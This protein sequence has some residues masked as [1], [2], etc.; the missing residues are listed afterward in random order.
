VG[1]GALVLV[2]LAVGVG[3]SRRTIRRVVVPLTRVR[4]VLAALAAE[5]HDARVEPR[6]P[7]EIAAIADGVNRLADSTDRLRAVEEAE[8]RL[9][10]RLVRLS[11]TVR[12]TQDDQ[13]IMQRGLAELGTALGLERAYLRILTN[14]SAGRIEAEWHDPELEPLPREVHHHTPG[15]SDELDELV[16]NG[17]ARVT[18]DVTDDPA[19]TSDQGRAWVRLVGAG[20]TMAVPVVAGS[21]PIAVLSVIDPAPRAWTPA[22]IHFA[23]SVAAD[24]GRALADARLYSTQVEALQRLEALDRAKDDFISGVSHELR[25]PLTS[26]SGYL[27]LLE[28][29]AAEGGS[30]SQSRALTVVRRNVERLG[31]LIEDLLTLSRIES[32]AFQTTRRHVDVAAVARTV[33]EDVRPQA[34]ARGVDLRHR[35]TDDA[36]VLGDDGQLGRALLNL[37]GNAVKFTPR[38]GSVEV[39]VE[40]ETVPD[41]EVVVRVADT[42]IGIPAADQDQLFQRFFRA[43]NALAAEVP[44]TG[45]GLTIVRTITENHRGHLDVESV[46]G[47]GTTVR[48][49]LPRPDGS[50]QPA[51]ESSVEA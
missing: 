20:A 50:G 49:R 43:S 19:Y 4:Q 47:E 42:G 44:G 37:V 33:L 38:D 17:G 23:E 39:T 34:E 15:G 12:S 32:G 24:L 41:Q 31:G 13:H 40:V 5:R 1:V 16:R 21:E 2:G 48:V 29:E 14:S 10:E 26:I 35:F 46:E 3:T 28:D 36:T 9:Q 11:W 30:R 45:L 8:R 18:Y 27:E 22:E 25:T 7:R 6:G 51:V